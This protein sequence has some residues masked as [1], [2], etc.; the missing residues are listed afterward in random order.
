MPYRAKAA[1]VGNSKALRLDSALFR[2]HP[3]FAAGEFAVSVIAPGCMLVQAE[4]NRTDH[5]AD[6]VFD[7]FV[8]FLEHQMAQ[9]P[10]LIS[11][12][13]RSDRHEADEILRGVAPDPHA[14]LGPDFSLSQ[15]RRATRSR[16]RTKRT[17]RT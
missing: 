6:P 8:T 1:T 13:A 10:D 2:E 11:A 3:E 17:A 4:A 15:P 16:R 5:E 7:A 9:R 14:D 12:A